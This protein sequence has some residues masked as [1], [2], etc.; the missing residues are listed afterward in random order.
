MTDIYAFV[1]EES[2]RNGIS[3]LLQEILVHF[4]IIIC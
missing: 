3:N 1:W 4:K 2:Y